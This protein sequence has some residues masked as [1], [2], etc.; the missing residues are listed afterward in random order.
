[1]PEP[2][3]AIPSSAAPDAVMRAYRAT[4][5]AQRCP[6]ASVYRVVGFLSSGTYGRVYK[7]EARSDGHMVAIKKFKPER[8]R[9]KA[10]YTGISQSAMREIALNRELRHE[11][12]NWLYRVMLEDRSISMILEFAEHDFLQLLQ[13][14]LSVLRTPIALAVVKSL[15]WQLLNGVEYLH[16]NWVMHR[17]LKPANI[18]VTSGGVVKIADLGLAR[19][20]A[21]PLLPLYTGDVVVVTIWYRAPELLLGARNYTTAIDLWA[22]GCIWGE[23]IALRPLFKG[24]EARVDPKTK[25]APFQAHQLGKIVD[26]LGTPDR[27]RWPKVD[28]MPDYSMW[29]ATRRANSVPKTLFQ[30]FTSRARTSSGYDLFDRLLQYDPEKRLTATEALQHEWFSEEPLPTRNAFAS[31]SAQSAPYPPRKVH[32]SEPDAPQTRAA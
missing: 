30:W 19:I 26:V 10:A 14:H 24:E 12:V 11:N 1:M 8:D 2:P 23:L 32:A 28:T 25:N 21:D 31:C 13:H 20:C 5:D 15:L 3:C 16:R 27:E 9:E 17:D 4:R 29:M 22:I 18:L 6:I 7:A